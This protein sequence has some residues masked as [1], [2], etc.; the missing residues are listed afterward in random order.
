LVL[1]ANNLNENISLKQ[2]LWVH[3]K[4]EPFGKTGINP[5]K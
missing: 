2:H 3:I 5:G 4:D 1:V